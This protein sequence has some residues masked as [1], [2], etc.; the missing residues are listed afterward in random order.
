M[1]VRSHVGTRKGRSETRI[2]SGGWLQLSK[3]SRYGNAASILK[4]IPAHE[5]ALLEAG[6]RG[7]I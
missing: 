1:R 3:A 5:S 4:P 6:G 7:G 2:V